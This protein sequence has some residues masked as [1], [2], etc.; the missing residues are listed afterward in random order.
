L[1]APRARNLN[2][3][4]YI[5][6]STTIGIMGQ[7][8]CYAGQ[9]VTWDQFEKADFFYQPLPENVNMD[10]EPP[11][12]PGPDSIYPVFVPGRHQVVVIANNSASIVS[13]A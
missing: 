11:V 13:H 2:N 4:D 6:R 9:Q 7:L 10:T 5:V 3:G 12:K 1:R 8:S